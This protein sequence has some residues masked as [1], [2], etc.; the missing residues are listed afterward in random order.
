MSVEFE[1]WIG[2]DDKQGQNAGKIEFM[3]VSD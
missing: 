3:Q 1:R 2:E